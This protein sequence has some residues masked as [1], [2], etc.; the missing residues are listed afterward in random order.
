MGDSSSL[1]K[2][3]V[4]NFSTALR[5]TSHPHHQTTHHHD[6]VNFEGLQENFLAHDF[7]A[8]KLCRMQNVACITNVDTFTLV[9]F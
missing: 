4:V 8:S 3:Q 7:F 9:A 5:L 2:E 6:T 1:V